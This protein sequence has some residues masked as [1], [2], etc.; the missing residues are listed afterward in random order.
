MLEC[1]RQR[2]SVHYRLPC[3]GEDEIF[4]YIL[5]HLKVAGLNRQIFTDEA[6]R[7]IYQCSK[8]MPHRVNNICRYALV[9]A[10]QKDD[11]WLVCDQCNSRLD[12]EPFVVID[13]P[14][15]EQLSD[16]ENVPIGSSALCQACAKK[17]YHLS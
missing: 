16:P 12:W 13:L 3:L 2:I 1:I 4:A 10:A 8:G 6:I 11:P 7:L 15:E 5:H 9:A 17:F 14:S